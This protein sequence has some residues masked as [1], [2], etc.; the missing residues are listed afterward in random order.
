MQAIEP[1]KI[2]SLRRAG[3]PANLQSMLRPNKKYSIYDLRQLKGKRCLTHVHVKSPEE[4]AAAETAGIDLLSCSFDSAAAQARLPLLVAAA[5]KSF[6]SGSTPHGMVPP[7]RRSALDSRPSNWAPV[8]SIA[9]AAPGSLR[10]WH[11]RVFRWLATW[12]WFHDML[13][14]PTFG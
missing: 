3:R 13:R 1:A 10:R 11:E 9:P 12:E 5:P 8:R 2:S 7:K 14:G 4:G 6:I